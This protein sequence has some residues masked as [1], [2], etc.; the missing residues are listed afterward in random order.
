M[1]SKR[2]TREELG[3]LLDLIRIHYTEGGMTARE[4]V[5]TLRP[6]LSVRQIHNYASEYD[7][8]KY[9]NWSERAQ[10]WLTEHHGDL[11]IP[12]LADQLGK[13]GA[14]IRSKLKG[15]GLVD[16]DRPDGRTQTRGGVDD[17]FF[18]HFMPPV[19][20]AGGFF[21]AD[22]SI[23]G[24]SALSITQHA[25]RDHLVAILRE[26]I[27]VEN[28]AK[29]IRRGGGAIGLELSWTSR[30]HVY[31]LEKVWGIT[32]DKTTTLAI[33]DRLFAFGSEEVLKAYLLGYFLGDGHITYSGRNRD[34]LTVAFSSASPAILRQI[35]DFADRRFPGM[36]PNGRRADIVEAAGCLRWAINGAR[37]EA[38]YAW[39]TSARVDSAWRFVTGKLND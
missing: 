35:R 19:A 33:P 4:F 1:P 12:E 5:D 18:D 32:R 13:S 9:P 29:R 26:M 10:R 27:G 23:L 38:F 36:R 7:L 34:S 21:A 11:S 30:R 37:A 8:Q 2:H 28:R 39:L 3:E 14:A 22:G 15:L 6:D 17:A 16:V 31:A 24:D 20:V 25:P